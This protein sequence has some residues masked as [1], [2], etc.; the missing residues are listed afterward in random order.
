MIK[1]DYS[2]IGNDIKDIV[3]NALNSDEFKELNKNISETVNRAM[4]EV[5]RSGQYWQ[6]QQR[7]QRE[8]NQQK[9]QQDRINNSKPRQTTRKRDDQKNNNRLQSNN[10]AQMP[11]KNLISK[12]PHGRVS[13]VLL[14]VF[15][16]IGIGLSLLFFLIFSFLT[17]VAFESLPLWG[18]ST[19]VLLPIFVISVLMA[20]RGSGLRSRVK[21][22][23]QYSSRLKGR[24]FCKITELSEPIGRSKK[25][26]VK[27]LRKMIRLGMFPEGRIDA[28]EN[29]LLI[30]DEAYENHLKLKE[31][32]RLEA[33]EAR[34]EQ[35]A[36]A[37]K[38]KLEAEN[39]QM[40][41]VHEVITEGNNIISEI[42]AANVAIEGEVI[43]LKLDR[44]EVVITKIFGFI[45]DN[46]DGLPEIRKFMG[47]YLPTTLKLVGVYRDLDAETIQGANIMATK[48]E[49]EDT[50][51]TINHAFENLLDSFYEDT[52]MDVSS[53]ISV[54]NTMLAQ[55]GLTQS[56]FKNK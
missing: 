17:N 18:V 44:L 48:K 56:D 50:L 26:V 1:K 25:Y 11:K 42:N 19:G 30:S 27:D 15:G 3:Q 46:P 31:G 5:K 43:S 2:N 7:K 35:E 37:R 6:E 28:D 13:G 45:E 33:E 47:Y 40:K 55:E 21:R 10:S 36:L 34:S 22:F 24:N 52:A 16:N 20:A 41:E 9:S 51:D 53:D 49:I 23:R 29:Y 12:S 14:M 32:K 39:P 4:D 54:L 38:K 8:N